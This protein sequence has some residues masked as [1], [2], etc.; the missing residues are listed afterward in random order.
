MYNLKK[1][2]KEWEGKEYLYQTN[3]IVVAE[4][5]QDGNSAIIKTSKKEF[6]IPIENAETFLQ[7][8]FLPIEPQNL[9]EEV[10]DVVITNPQTAVDFVPMQ[11]PLMQ[12]KDT[13]AYLK[14]TLIDSIKKVQEDANYIPQAEAVNKAVGTLIDLAKAQMEFFKNFKK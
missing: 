11:E 13:I 9:K 4:I 8:N 14:H 1:I 6:R 5:S 3:R 10:K 12:D 7:N 2:K